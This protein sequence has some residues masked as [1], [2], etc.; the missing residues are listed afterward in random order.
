MKFRRLLPF[1]AVLSLLA[2]LAGCGSSAKLFTGTPETGL[3]MM[4]AME[5]GETLSYRNETK[6]INSMEMMGQP[7]EVNASNLTTY[8]L[9]G[10]SMDRDSGLV[11]EIIVDTLSMKVQSPQGNQ[12]PDLSALTGKP[13]TLALSPQGKET[14]KGV[15]S[16]KIN[17]GPM[18]GG[19]QSITNMLRNIFQDLPQGAVKIGDSWETDNTMTT[20]QMGAEVN[21]HTLG[22]HTFEKIEMMGGEPCVKIVSVSEATLDGEG[23]QM[24]ASMTI[25]GDMTIEAIWYF[26]YQKGRLIKMNSKSFMEGTVAV[27]GAANMTIPMT[28]EN[29][30][31]ITLVN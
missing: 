19:E 9:T 15:D 4:Y 12:E 23:E 20:P 25:E 21:V 22:K 1:F 5:K 31:Q 28:V 13:F 24:G 3:T 2:L 27:S 14:F 17:M 29:S 10:Q 26:A 18:S 11:A 16:L 8:T 7:M 6:T 30:T